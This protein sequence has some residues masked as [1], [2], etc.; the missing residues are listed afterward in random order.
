MR[1]VIPDTDS[2]VSWNEGPAKQAIH[3]FVAAVT[4]KN[5]PDFVPVAER[6][7]TFD[8]D[9]TLWAEQPLYFQLNFAIALFRR[10]YTASPATRSSAALAN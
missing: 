10:R 3:D 8:N 4:Q 6:I 7:A 2:L 1:N 5:S 9:G